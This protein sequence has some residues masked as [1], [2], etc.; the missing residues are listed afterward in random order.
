MLFDCYHQK[1]CIKELANMQILANVIHLGLKP[2]GT[3]FEHKAWSE[4]FDN[5]Y[6]TPHS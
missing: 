4:Q 5:I 2:S 6:Y 3:P 1:Q